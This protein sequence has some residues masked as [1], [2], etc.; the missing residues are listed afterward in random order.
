MNNDWNNIEK[1]FKSTLGGNPGGDPV[2]PWEGIEKRVVRS[3]FFRFN[4]STFNVYSLTIIIGLIST[5]GYA[6]FKVASLNKELF[7][8]NEII[9]QY[10]QKEMEE[11]KKPYKIDSI[12]TN[13]DSIKQ[14]RKTNNDSIIVPQQEIVR[15]IVEPIPV[16]NDVKKSNETDYLPDTV[17]RVT[18]KRKVVRKQVVVKKTQQ[19]KDSIVIK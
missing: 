2:D 19:V 9:R 8:K 14:I 15:E 1:L 5:L 16:K 4:L 17:T 7:R 3:N 11:T 13:T 10:Q 6:S 18:I 12:N